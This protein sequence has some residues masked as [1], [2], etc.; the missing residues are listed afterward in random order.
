M[1]GYL[2]MLAIGGLI[3]G[4]LAR[5]VIPGRNPMGIGMTILLGIAGAF[6][7]GIVGNALFQRPGGLILSVAGAAFLVWLFGR[8]RFA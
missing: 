7:G 4:A 1:L 5:L 3:I 6:L 8:R 2:I